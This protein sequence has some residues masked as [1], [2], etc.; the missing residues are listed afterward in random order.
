MLTQ[1]RNLS[2][3]KKHIFL[4][5][6]MASYA[7]TNIAFADFEESWCILYEGSSEAACCL[8]LSKNAECTQY[9]EDSEPKCC[10]DG[11][12][13][14]PVEINQSA[15]APEK[16]TETEA[17]PL[18]PLVTNKEELPAEGETVNIEVEVVTE[19]ETAVTER[20]E[21]VQNSLPSEPESNE[22]VNTEYEVVTD[23]N[24]TG[25]PET[26][27][28][29]ETVSSLPFSE[30]S[31]VLSDDNEKPVVKPNART[32]P[33]VL[34]IIDKI[35][36]NC[37]PTAKW[38]LQPSNN[39]RVV[40]NKDGTLTYVANHNFNGFDEF[41]YT[42]EK[43]G[44]VSTNKVIVEVR[45]DD[46]GKNEEAI[47]AA[48]NLICVLHHKKGI[49][50]VLTTELG[51]NT[52]EQ[53]LTELSF[54][55][56]PNKGFDMGGCDC[57]NGQCYAVL[58]SS[59][60][61]LDGSL[62]ELNPQE[63][64]LKASTGIKTTAIAFHPNGVLYAWSKDG[65]VEIEIDK[66]TVH[67]KL[68]APAEEI[69]GKNNKV[70]IT[71][72][73][74]SSDG[75]ELYAIVNG[76]LWVLAFDGKT[77]EKKKK[78]TN[79]P[80]KIEFSLETLK[81]GPLL[82]TSLDQD[83]NFLSA[84]DYDPENCQVRQTP[85]DTTS[86][87]PSVVE[88]K[89]SDAEQSIVEEA[90]TPS[91]IVNLF[92]ANN[93]KVDTS[94]KTEK[95]ESSQTPEPA[96]IL[97]SEPSKPSENSQ[98]VDNKEGTTHTPEADA[99]TPKVDS[100]TP[101]EPAAQPSE[102]TPAVDNEEDALAA[103]NEADTSE[104]EADEKP[105]GC[106]CSIYAVHD[107]GE[108]DSQ[109][110]ITEN[111]YGKKDVREIGPLYKGYN[112]EAMEMD[113]K[114]RQLYAI[115]NRTH[116]SKKTDGYLYKVDCKT[117]ELELIGDTGFSGITALT[118]YP[119]DGGIPQLGGMLVGY[120]IHGAKEGPEK[121]IGGLVRIYPKTA[122]TE[123]LFPVPKEVKIASLA[124]NSDGT[125]LY[126]TEKNNNLWAINFLNK[127]LEIECRN[128]SEIEGL[129]T[130]KDGKLLF[131][132]PKADYLWF[133]SYDPKIN[134]DPD[135]CMLGITEY[136]AKTETPYDVESIAWP[137]SCQKTREEII[138][139]CLARKIAEIVN[140]ENVRLEKSGEGALLSLEVA[141]QVH[142]GYFPQW[143]SFNELKCDDLTLAFTAT[144]DVNGDGFSDL[145]MHYGN[146][147]DVNGE[148]LPIQT[149]IPLYYL[150]VEEVLEVVDEVVEV[151]KEVVVEVVEIEDELDEQ[152]EV[153]V[154]VVDE[155][156]ST[157]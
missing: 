156:E 39:S 6:L 11:K 136:F 157:R 10:I 8:E 155:V 154:E 105:V 119:L 97:S 115:S 93:G 38:T 30:A 131:A 111:P 81:N 32:Q 43:N 110:L 36:E 120:S 125:L 5:S 88:E 62:V 20:N 47:P 87:T 127:T 78:C 55:P 107:E 16:E 147:L 48:D 135:K 76:K 139:E 77:F 33:A 69:F 137:L 1:I 72:L 50:H 149:T 17:N 134:A 86:D 138:L 57:Q 96:E 104:N 13:N 91:S 42:C 61:A 152:V 89:T 3:M 22:V 58:N 66:K 153:V 100:E 52:A 116:K 67:T 15:V 129:E 117:G 45:A 46:R 140:L 94:Q 27:L 128:F 14:T 150:G 40:D 35:S 65:I 44:E 109:F 31:S 123:L 71:S 51:D 114:S 54:S 145:E 85:L 126:A 74:W 148:R 101:E 2:L 9:E 7:I 82:L 68:V 63:V 95:A 80:K 79:L 12:V 122:D 60:K 37:D 132:I 75:K 113:P 21:T 70:E 142:Q 121:G 23:R 108:S 53:P 24:E 112:I 59:S 103:T 151:V 83:G 41:Y 84:I 25:L 99:G 144:E 26:G 19:P 98:E 34:T 118:F 102:N 143:S 56:L 4:G 92:V 130:L 49:L 90:G 18:P 73:A 133:V 141:G 64:I 146:D 28:P 29:D 106:G 124:W